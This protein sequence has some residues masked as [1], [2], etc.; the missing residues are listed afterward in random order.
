MIFVMISFSG[1]EDGRRER[2][3]REESPSHQI[4]NAKEDETRVIVNSVDEELNIGS[5]TSFK[6]YE[7][8]ESV[9]LHNYERED[10]DPLQRKFPS[11]CVF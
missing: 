10:K 3:A 11:M 4:A 8:R 6:D 5:T 9:E 7:G 1:D 2:D